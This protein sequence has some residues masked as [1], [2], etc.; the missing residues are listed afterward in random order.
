MGIAKP[1][2]RIAFLSLLAL[3]SLSLG[4]A[5][6][7]PARRAA[8]G[9]VAG[10]FGWPKET[11]CTDQTSGTVQTIEPRYL[12][13]RLRLAAQCHFTL[14]I[15]PPRKQLTVTGT[16]SGGFSVESAERL[17][18]EYAQVLTPDVL[19]QYGGTILGF[20]LGDDYKCR[21][22]W[23]GEEIT[24]AQI[25]T[26]AQY[27]RSRI[28]GLP[29]G[30]RMT[31]DWVEKYPS[32][33]PLLDYAWAQYTTQDGDPKKYYD[34]AA[35]DAQHLGIQIVMGINVQNC[36]GPRTD[37]CSAAELGRIGAVAVTHPASCAFLN[38]RYDPGTWDR[39]DIQ[40]VW[41]DL[42]AKAKARPRRDCRASH[43]S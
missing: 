7:H 10:F 9:F 24:P 20:N 13:D 16:S 2:M 21:N 34:E 42:M 12:L 39:Q 32:L 27:T 14:V 43:L 28:P 3:A 37:P 33:A 5:A 26:W 38:W 8:G 36:G 18:D 35:R 29:L 31:P 41:N 17:M 25:A 22:C 19:R 4:A 30:V 6:A 15:E 1:R 23:G 40:A 11:Y